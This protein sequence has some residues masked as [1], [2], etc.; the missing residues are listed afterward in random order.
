MLSN[1]PNSSLFHPFAKLSVWLKGSL[2]YK[3]GVVN[4]V[5]AMHGYI[6]HTLCMNALKTEQIPNYSIVS[7]IQVDTTQ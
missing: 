4:Q 3:V 7:T 1:T 5:I 6:V 2:S